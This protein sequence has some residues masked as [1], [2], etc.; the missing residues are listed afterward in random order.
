M[1]IAV[2]GAG[3]A[4]L[5]SAITLRAQGHRCHIYERMRQGHETGMG[6]ILMPDG[7][8]CLQS[9]GVKLTGE[10]S[11]APLHRYFCRSSSGQILYEQ[12]LPTGTRSIRR[13]QL[14]DA[15][16]GA[17]PPDITP[18]F[19]AELAALECD[20]AG[21]VTQARLNTG[22]GVKADLYV[23]AEGFRSRA[24]QAL[25]PGWP[26]PQAQVLEIVGMV[27]CKSTV[28]WASNNF[29]KFH[30]VSGG[31]ALGTLAVDSEHIVWYLQFD[32]QR[33]PQPPENAGNF[34]ETRKAFVTS[35]VGDWADPIPHLLSIADFS[36]THLW[37]PV[38][39]DLIPA[40]YRRNLVLVGDA[41]HPLSPFTSQGV[42]SAVADAVAL[43]EN[44]RPAN[45]KTPSDLEK[46]LAS[47]SA[48]RR[49]QCAPYVA[50]GRELTRHFLTPQIGSTIL[51]P[52]A[53]PEQAEPGSFSDNIVRLDLLRERAFNMRW[54]QQP[55]DV[56]PL[57]AADPDFPVCPAIQEQLVR[58][59]RDGVLSYGPP[60]GLPQFR[61]SVARW[62]QETRQMECS[63][64]DVFATDSAASGMAVLARASLAPGDEVLIPDP[65][66]FL[67]HHT[68][69][70]A[71]AIPVRVRVGPRTSAEEFIRGME[72]HLSRRTRMLWL[73]NPHN[74]LGVVYSR[75]WQ[76]R[77]AEWAISRGLRIVSDEIWSDIV[78][79]PHRHV[80][81]ASISPEIAR[82]T[83]TVYGFSK[84]FALA[85]LRV[86]CLIC[87][88]QEWKKE[89]IAASDAESTV[90]GV[91]VLSQVA[92]VAALNDGR[93]WLAQFVQHLQA[94]RDYVVGRLATWPGVTVE[95][96][97]GTYVV[98]PDVRS[99]SD[100]SETLC[101]QL[102]EQARVAL[103][104]GAPKWFGPGA[105]GHLRICFATSHRILQEAFDRLEPVVTQIANERH[106]IKVIH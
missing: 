105:S 70:R 80:S 39:T 94:Q 92:V 46:A 32:S 99:L 49:Q 63:A 17:L 85:G 19:D 96:P 38:D 12:P 20:D 90:Y 27:Q 33:F 42:S 75:D 53:E 104:P 57:T 50:K 60:E 5:M 44:L 67:L 71:G 34:A 10:N 29:N 69:Q 66:D 30:A 26:S 95:P 73:C 48:E 13:R 7:I 43:A 51:L 47:Y 61:E 35:L 87:P 72:S 52:I 11:G 15:L 62:M 18:R 100:D 97:Q 91:S 78:Y 40:F 8:D 55:A 24:R 41:A 1:E 84:N 16:M 37:R 76:Q 82:N 79:K 31:I 98:F 59:V 6:F 93:E 106:L 103:V 25:Y 22:A 54:A 2:F 101:Q 83:V 45:L 88:D 89:I 77:V 4:G 56:I 9:F 65:V 74:P 68:V 23:S 81:V 14:I 3:I 86:G 64:E 102:R 36:R 58:H 21:S 28:R